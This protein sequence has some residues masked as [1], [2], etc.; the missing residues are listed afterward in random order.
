MNFEVHICVTS[1]LAR[2]AVK[3]WGP[4]DR[5]SPQR[6]SSCLRCLQAER[7]PN[8]LDVLES[9]KREVSHCSLNR[10]MT[11]KT[12]GSPNNLVSLIKMCVVM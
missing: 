8:G 6:L 10:E 4:V 12:V 2:Q 1:F 11:V 5:A 3:L 7:L 9:W